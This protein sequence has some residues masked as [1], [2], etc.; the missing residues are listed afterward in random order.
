MRD[1]GVGVGIR[2]DIRAVGR[3][4]GVGVSGGTLGIRGGTRVCNWGSLTLRAGA[5][6]SVYNDRVVELVLLLSKTCENLK[7]SEPE[8]GRLQCSS[9]RAICSFFMS[10]GSSISGTSSIGSG[11]Y[12]ASIKSL[13]C[14]LICFHGTR[15]SL[16]PEA[17]PL[18]SRKLQS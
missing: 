13:V 17:K 16:R 7:R 3:T 18:D 11:R 15:S 5:K 2:G 14:S 10:L 12:L 8:T 1:G 9:S 4:G 6:E